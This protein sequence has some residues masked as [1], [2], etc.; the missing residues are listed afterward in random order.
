MLNVSKIINFL[1]CEVALID[2]RFYFIPTVLALPFTL[3]MTSI[4]AAKRLGPAGLL[5]ILMTLFYI[6]L[7]ILANRLKNRLKQIMNNYSI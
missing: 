7:T 2:P 1:G 4:L 5:A 3:S 6:P